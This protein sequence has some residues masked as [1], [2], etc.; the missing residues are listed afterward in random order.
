MDFSTW[1][2]HAVKRVPPDKVPDSIFMHPPIRNPNVFRFTSTDGGGQAT[3]ERFG[4][5]SHAERF[6]TARQKHEKSNSFTSDTIH[7]PN[8]SRAAHFQRSSKEW[9]W[10]PRGAEGKLAGVDL[11]GLNPLGHDEWIQVILSSFSEP[12]PGTI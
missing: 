6:N 5:R 12:W 3:R 7:S 2:N 4:F 10:E 1:K 8:V 9:S 11:G